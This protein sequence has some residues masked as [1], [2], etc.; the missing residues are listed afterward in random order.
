MKARKYETD[1]HPNIPKQEVVRVGTVLRFTG[2]DGSV[3]PFSDSVV[4]GI[5]WED[6]NKEK[7]NALTLA[8]AYREMRAGWGN[9]DTDW[10]I[11][12]HLARPYIY[13]DSI[14]SI[15]NC[16][17]G[18]EKYSIGTHHLLRHYKVVEMSTGEAANYNKSNLAV[19]E[20]I[21]GNVGSVYTGTSS[22]EA[23]EKYDSYVEKSKSRTGGRVC[24]EFVTLMKDGEIIK[25]HEGTHEQP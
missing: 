18:V 13:A 20:V 1:G 12:I 16:L 11:N 15:H 2:S 24:G 22:S 25:E 10:R 19:Y 17:Q 4:I 8:E 23:I 6:K 5:S 14:G 7:H 21:V 9:T 3:S